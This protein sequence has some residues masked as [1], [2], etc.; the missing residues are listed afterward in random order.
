MESYE[1]NINYYNKLK[2]RN[3]TVK[4]LICIYF[5]MAIITL[6]TIWIIYL[7]GKTNNVPSLTTPSNN[8]VSYII[9]STPYYLNN[10]LIII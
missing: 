3:E 7:N 4:Y 5:L 2:K 10:T 8:N 9:S 6:Y 1:I